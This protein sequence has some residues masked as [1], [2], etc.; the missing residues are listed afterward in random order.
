MCCCC[1]KQMQLDLHQWSNQ[2]SAYY[3]MKV[4]DSFMYCLHNLMN[5]CTT[6]AYWQHGGVC[7]CCIFF[8]QQGDEVKLTVT[9]AFHLRLAQHVSL[10]GNSTKSQISCRSRFCMKYFHCVWSSEDQQKII[11]GNLGTALP[12][13]DE[14]KCNMCKLSHLMSNNYNFNIKCI[15][16]HTF[17]QSD[18]CRLT[19]VKIFPLN[20]AWWEPFPLCVILKL[21]QFKANPQ[22]CVYASW[23]VICI[24]F[25][26]KQAS[27][28]PLYMQNMWSW[29]PWGH[30]YKT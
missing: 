3:S 2:C 14:S 15:T 19:G 5:R 25:P 23:S 29:T 30:E 18:F 10:K 26:S 24:D 21:P 22:W 28:Y 8:L 7:G 17:L 27:R 11:R 12:L 6:E 16:T 13:T 20:A 4:A 1:F 9:A